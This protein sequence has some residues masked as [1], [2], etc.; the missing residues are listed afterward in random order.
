M[1]LETNL[2]TVQAMEILV[3][4]LGPVMSEEE[5]LSEAVMEEVL[6]DVGRVMT[7]EESLIL[8]KALAIADAQS[9]TIPDA[10]ILLKL[11]KTLA[12]AAYTEQSPLNKV[13]D[14]YQLAV[15]KASG[16]CMILASGETPKRE[17]IKHGHSLIDRSGV[18]RKV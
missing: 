13:I 8:M 5:S 4:W 17:R 1:S 11:H 16:T 10:N 3:L 7:K 9:Q 14:L 18:A 2:L 15:T 6:E 12:K